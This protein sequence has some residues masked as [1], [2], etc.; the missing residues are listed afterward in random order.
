M[1][2]RLARVVGGAACCVALSSVIAGAGGPDDVTSWVTTSQ[3]DQ[4]E[5]HVPAMGES[6]RAD[7]FRGR[8]L[9][10]QVWVVAPAQDADVDGLGP[11]Y[12]R[13]S[14]IACHPR[15]GRG[16]APEGPEEEMRAM[17]VRL[18]LPGVGPHGGPRMHPVY[19][20]QL[21]ELAIPGVVPEGRAVIRWEEHT[22]ELAGGESVRLRRPV[23]DFRDLG[24]GPLG[25]DVLVS[26]R[27]G[28]PVYGLGLLEAVPDDAIMA[29]ARREGVIAG[30][31]NSVWDVAQGRMVLG[32]FGWKANQPTLRQ[33]VAA[34]ALGDLG[35]TSSLFPEE[36]C[37][38]VQ[39]GCAQ[40]P[41]GGDPEL[42]D[43]Q[44]DAMELYL[45]LLAVPAR[46][47][48]D[49]PD[50]RRG[51]ALFREFGCGDC[52]VPELRTGAHPRFPE[53]AN[54]TIRPYTDLLLHDMGAGL[55][56]GR[57]DFGAR[58]SEWRTP[59]LW[60]IGLAG[61]AGRRAGYLHD[62]RARTLLEA[63]LWHGGQ[64]AHARDSVAA[65]DPED[66]AALLRFLDSL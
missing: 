61:R 50:V 41:G 7:F 6:R 21:N 17:L 13:L 56:D 30:R 66:R 32:R 19:G 62:G 40:A 11:L 57:P 38:V 4:F 59:P 39:T 16:F 35:I 37:T 14:C 31:P 44:L 60:G 36:T 8:N 22:V 3:V 48:A 2:G 64:A 10:R 29:L 47:D 65:A 53:L 58:G 26:L 42:T 12:N 9:F 45:Q 33:Q 1:S 43:A 15:N 27:I 25:Q 18:G 23:V 20:E 34:A 51:E 28:Q 49:R 5:Q 54:R 46:R 63:V 52:H 55:A 24:Y